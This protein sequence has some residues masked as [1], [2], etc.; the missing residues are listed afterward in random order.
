MLA[1][2]KS[3]NFSLESASISPPPLQSTLRSH[4]PWTAVAIF[5]RGLSSFAIDILL[6]ILSA[7]E[8]LRY[9]YEAG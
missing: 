8:N 4:G 3:M 9:I 5:F 2:G 7:A 6:K 1:N